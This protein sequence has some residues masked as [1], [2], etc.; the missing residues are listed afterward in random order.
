MLL[1]NR[2]PAR[3]SARRMN[4]VLLV[5]AGVY[6]AAP[7]AA[8]DNGVTAVGEICMQKVYGAPV[9]NANRL[10]CTASDIQLSRAI[11]VSPATCMRGE[12]FD[13]TATFETIVTANARYDAAFYFRIDGEGTAR[14][15]G[16]QAAGTCSL[17]ALTAPPAPALKLDADLCGDLNAGTHNVTFTIP[18]VVCEPGEGTNHLRL[19]NCTSWHSNQGTACD[20]GELVG[21]PIASALDFEPDTKAKC[22]CDDDFTVPVE[23]EDATIVVNKTVDPETFPEPGGDATYTVVITNSSK[24]ESVTIATIVDDVYGDLGGGDVDASVTYNDCPALI[25]E[26][27]APGASTFCVFQAQVYGAPGTGVTDAADVCVL[28]DAVAEP[29]CD[30]DNSSVA[31]VDKYAAPTLA[32]TVESC[33]LD[34]EYQ[35]VVNNNS[36]VDT[37]TVMSLADDRFGEVSTV[38]PAGGGFDAVTWTDC[39]TPSE[40]LTIAPMGE[41]RCKFRGKIASETCNV[42][43]HKSTVNSQVVDDDAHANA[44]SGA[45]T[46][47][48]TSTP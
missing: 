4:V 38:H 30:G 2:T 19:P 28:Q 36:D 8:A 24:Y 35:V 29:I 42:P 43:G 40:S 44:L 12:I 37:L 45:T 34:V 33:V 9:T 20:I 14:G 1:R 7:I 15:D 22:V 17:S 23:V 39:P 25:G 11:S 32:K 10:N 3:N 21:E 26:V 16:P 18:D 13:L 27:L 6:L 31:I 46:V 48:V 41:L 47:S 5:G